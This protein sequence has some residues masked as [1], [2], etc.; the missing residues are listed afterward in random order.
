M[1]RCG[2]TTEY[3]P[4]D[5]SPPVIIVSRELIRQIGGRQCVDY[6]VKGKPIIDVKVLV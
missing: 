6:V 5:E 2:P 4:V 1:S 3:L